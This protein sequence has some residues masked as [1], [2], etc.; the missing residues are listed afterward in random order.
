[1]E[2]NTVDFVGNYKTVEDRDEAEN[3]L[4]NGNDYRVLQ[5]RL[6]TDANH[7]RKEVAF[8]AL[9]LVIGTAVKGRMD[10]ATP[11]GDDLT[12]FEVDIDETTTI[13]HIDAPLGDPHLVLRGTTSR[14]LYDAF[15][16]IRT[17]NSA[18]PQLAVTYTMSRMT[19]L[20]N[21]RPGEQT[22]VHHA[23]SYSDRFGRQIQ[24]ILTKQGPVVKRDT[25]GNI[26]LTPGSDG[27]IIFN[28]KSLP[29]R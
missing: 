18:S 27:W 21:L 28:S 23:F 5:S 12:N 14:L 19:H 17:K 24:K 9:G 8:N 26:I 13:Q 2:V 6:M 10:D 16:Y 29:V 20:S 1:M 3:M 11:S 22:E 25:D 15:A 4:S 7:N